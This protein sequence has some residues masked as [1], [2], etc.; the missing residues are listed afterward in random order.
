MEDLFETIH[1]IHQKDTEDVIEWIKN[2]NKNPEDNFLKQISKEVIQDIFTTIK[3]LESP[4]KNN[5]SDIDE[6][7]IRYKEYRNEEID[8]IKNSIIIS[9]LKNQNLDIIFAFPYNYEPLRNPWTEID[10]TY[11][12]VI[13]HHREVDEKIQ[14]V[15]KDGIYDIVKYVYVAKDEEPIYNIQTIFIKDDSI[16]IN[17]YGMGSMLYN[18][19]IYDCIDV[20]Q[21]KLAV[22]NV[23]YF[24]NKCENNK[25]NK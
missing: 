8:K 24:M 16:R 14:D 12:T 18:V 9:L 4:I 19:K 1:W 17:E 20:F 23:V 3:F 6:L 5:K 15:Y 22:D 2:L 11:F 10:R 21:N 13:V 7:L 25:Q